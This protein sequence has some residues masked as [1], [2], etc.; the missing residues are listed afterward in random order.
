M[1]ENSNIC[2]SSNLNKLFV[3]LNLHNYDY[4]SKMQLLRQFS[5]YILKDLKKRGLKIK[6]QLLFDTIFAY[7]LLNFIMHK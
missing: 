5:I 7:Y 4:F 1:I 6:I 2:S 3:L